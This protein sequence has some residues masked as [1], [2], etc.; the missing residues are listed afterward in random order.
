[1]PSARPSAISAVAASANHVSGKTTRSRR[2]VLR[3]FGTAIMP[4]GAT[5]IY[6]MATLALLEVVRP[7]VLAFVPG[8]AAAVALYCLLFVYN[9]TGQTVFTIGAVY[10]GSKVSMGFGRDLRNALF[11]A[12]VLVSTHYVLD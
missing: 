1:M 4:G 6:T 9:N 12:A 3:G 5:A 10:V 7:R 8:F 2:T 11:C